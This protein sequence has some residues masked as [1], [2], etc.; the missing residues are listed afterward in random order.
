M[1]NHVAALLRELEQLL[2]LH[3]RMLAC[4]RQRHEAMSRRQVDEL[5]RL[6]NEELSLAQA[7]QE[8][9][10][11]RQVTMLR[12]GAELGRQPRQMAGVNIE[13]LADWLPAQQRLALLELHSQLR[14]VVD[15]IRRLNATM[16]MLAQRSLPWFEELLGVLLGV[17]EQPVYTAR[18]QMAAPAALVA[19]GVVDIQI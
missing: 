6:M 8:V 1:S 13:Q 5:E 9:E 16:T 15:E 12:A 4:A 10:R 2:T 17:G 14:G 7:V 11:R 18:G 3:K 19:R